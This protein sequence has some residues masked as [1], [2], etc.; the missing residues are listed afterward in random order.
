[1]ILAIPIALRQS[2]IYQWVTRSRKLRKEN[3]LAKRKNSQKWYTSTTKKDKFQ[4]RV[5][6][7]LW[8]SERVNNSFST[9]GTRR[10]N[11]VEN[12]VISHC[13]F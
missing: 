1:M 2:C 6:V 3:T 12:H 5:Q 9:S 8:W 4:T 7:K 10:V 11:H 13:P